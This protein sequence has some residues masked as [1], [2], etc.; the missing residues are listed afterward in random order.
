MTL[1]TALGGI[2][3]IQRAPGVPSFATLLTDAVDADVLGVPVRI[4]S[5]GHLR[6]MKAATGRAQDRADLENLPEPG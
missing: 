2:D 5:L 6:A 4:S 1:D 3:V